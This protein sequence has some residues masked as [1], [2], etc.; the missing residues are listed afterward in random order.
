MITRSVIIEKGPFLI[1]IK[2]NVYFSHY[3]YYLFGGNMMFVRNA[4]SEDLEGQNSFVNISYK[5][6]YVVINSLGAFDKETLLGGGKN[7]E[8][9]LHK[10]HCK[11]L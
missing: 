1:E 7:N 8:F 6:F 11:I 2:D 5:Q 9:I 4:T 10:S 3:W